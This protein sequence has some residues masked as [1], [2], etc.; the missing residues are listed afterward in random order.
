MPA[1]FQ[2][3]IENIENMLIGQGVKDMT[4][5]FSDSNDL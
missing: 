1:M 4:T 3:L 2:A 5:G